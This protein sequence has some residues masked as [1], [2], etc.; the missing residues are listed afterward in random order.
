MPVVGCGR[1]DS[2]VHAR[3]Y[4]FHF[5]VDHTLEAKEVYGIDSLC[6]HDIAIR[7][8][9]PVAEDFHARF[10][11]KK[12]TY[13]YFILRDKDPFRRQESFFM[14]AFGELET[15]L[16]EACASYILDQNNFFA[17]CKTNSDTPHYLCQI[18][19]SKWEINQNGAIYWVSANR[20]LRGMVRLLVGSQLDVALGKLSFEEWKAVFEGENR[21]S[22]SWSVPAEGLF[23]MGLEY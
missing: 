17:F 7:K 9:A 15:N 4:V 6:G 3:N 5:D 13:Q 8:I 18:F 12:R 10:S 11:A 20:F 2:G 23:L 14:P 1:T 21:L 16:L 22:K 19:E